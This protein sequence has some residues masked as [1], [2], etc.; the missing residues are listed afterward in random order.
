MRGRVVDRSWFEGATEVAAVKLQ[1]ERALA[2][3]IDQRGIEA[4]ARIAEVKRQSKLLATRP[5][6]LGKYQSIQHWA[7]ALGFEEDTIRDW[8]RTG[9]IEGQWIRN[10]W[11]I[12]EEVMLE[13]LKQ[14]NESRARKG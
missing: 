8:C 7:E 3:Q 6:R 13:F 1:T 2:R 14:E 9:V 4:R 12:S 5:V 10:T 11:R